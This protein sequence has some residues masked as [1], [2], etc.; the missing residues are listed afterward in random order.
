M[1]DFMLFKELLYKYSVI[2]EN[3]SRESHFSFV[4]AVYSIPTGIKV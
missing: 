3:R 4:I 1:Y 2:R